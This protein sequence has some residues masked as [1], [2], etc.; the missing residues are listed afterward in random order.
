MTLGL[1]S[2]ALNTLVDFIV[3]LMA[4]TAHIGPRAPSRSC[5]SA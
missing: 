3:V 5:F 1:I 4:S 2:V